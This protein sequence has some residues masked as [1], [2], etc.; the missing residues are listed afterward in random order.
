M[1]S[2]YASI[3]G[4]Q[5]KD[6]GKCLEAS[7]QGQ[8]FRILSQS[9]FTEQNSAQFKHEI[10]EG[11]PHGWQGDPRPIKGSLQGVGCGLLFSEK[12][13]LGEGLK[14]SYDPSSKCRDADKKDNQG[15]K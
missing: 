5:R 15:A 8:V 9:P 10:A 6:L 7:R 4:K 14:H 1:V 13:N 2:G 3:K 11:H 12:P